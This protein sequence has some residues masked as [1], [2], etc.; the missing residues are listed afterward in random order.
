M[1]NWPRKTPNAPTMK[2]S[3][4]LVFFACETVFIPA[5]PAIA[6]RT[7]LNSRLSCRYWSASCATS[8]TTSSLPER[9]DLARGGERIGG[10]EHRG[11]QGD[12]GGA[13][14]LHLGYVARL[15]AANSI[16]GK[17]NFFHYFLQPSAALRFSVD[18]FRSEEH[19]SEL[20]SQ[21]H[22]VCRLLL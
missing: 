20:Q 21:F 4:G 13:A 8:F 11:D 3:A 6:A 7:I 9:A 22:L 1:A 10:G 19:T 12:A 14:L 5:K 17:R 16:N 2:K 15:N 18:G